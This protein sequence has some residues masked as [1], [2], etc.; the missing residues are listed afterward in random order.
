M[1]DFKRSSESLSAQVIWETS[2]T[3]QKIML[4]ETTEMLC[5][6]KTGVKER[7]LIP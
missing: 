6:E 2:E 3:Q 1:R 4:R 5:Y 7:R